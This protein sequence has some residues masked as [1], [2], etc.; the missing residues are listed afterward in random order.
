MPSAFQ[1]ASIV[2][3]SRFDWV[4][5]ATIEI[6]FN[7]P[8]VAI[9]SYNTNRI[10]CGSYAR[11]LVFFME[12]TVKLLWY[13]HAKVAANVS[14]CEEE[15]LK[16]KCPSVHWQRFLN[17]SLNLTTCAKLQTK[18][19]TILVFYLNCNSYSKHWNSS[20]FL[21]FI[22]MWKGLTNKYQILQ[23]NC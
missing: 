11:L 2:F 22:K 6:G 8:K 21:A 23:P 13:P 7:E 4:L 1:L 15:M 12:E 3:S 19:L 17:V 14:Y 5:E 20:D 18:I 9:W 10:L 16:Q